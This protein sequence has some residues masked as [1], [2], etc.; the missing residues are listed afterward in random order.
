MNKAKTDLEEWADGASTVDEAGARLRAGKTRTYW[1]MNEGYL[2]YK[3]H[4]KRRLISN[5]SI[6]R[7]LAQG[8]PSRTEIVESDSR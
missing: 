8:S 5:R 2:S 4:G 1:L 3:Q 6:T 7:L